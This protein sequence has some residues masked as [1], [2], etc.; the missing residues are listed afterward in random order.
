[1]L[2]AISIDGGRVEPGATVHLTLVQ[3]TEL[4]TAG[5]VGPHDPK[6]EARAAKAAKAA[7]AERAKAEEAAA[8]AAREAQA[9]AQ[10]EAEAEALQKQQD[11]Q[12]EQAGPSDL[13]GDAVESQG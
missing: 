6:A 3:Y 13:L 4:A 10:A 7:A 11:E 8:A 12:R 2:R 5:K 1:M 9:N